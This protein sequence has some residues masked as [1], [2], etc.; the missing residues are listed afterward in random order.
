MSALLLIHVTACVFHWISHWGTLRG[1]PSWISEMNLSK[2]TRSERYYA[3]LYWTVATLTTTGVSHG[4]SLALMCNLDSCFE[5][6]VAQ[7]GYLRI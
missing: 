5:T 2:G 3:S 4:G 7:N 1:L 6:K